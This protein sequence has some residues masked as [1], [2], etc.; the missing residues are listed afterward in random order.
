MNNSISQT[1]QNCIE[2][3]LDTSFGRGLFVNRIPADNGEK[4]G[5]LCPDCQSMECDTCNESALNWS[6]DK[7]GNIICDDCAN[8]NIEYNRGIA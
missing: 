5:Y 3:N 7:N 8:K 1:D 6:T 2:C 4:E